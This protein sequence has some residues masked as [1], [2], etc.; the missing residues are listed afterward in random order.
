L[1]T[2]YS[3]A[4]TTPFKIVYPSG[5]QKTIY[6][7]ASTNLRMVSHVP[8]LRMIASLSTQV[9]WYAAS[10]TT[11]QKVDP[12]G[13]IDTDL[14][15]HEITTEM[16]DDPDYTIKGVLLSKQRRNPTDNP[17]TVNPVISLIS[18]RLTKELGSNSTFSFYANNFLYYEPFQHNNVTTTLTQKNEGLFAFGAEL[19]FNF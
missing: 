19:T 16:L 11:N 9:I 1:P 14:S 2:A 17:T 8:S 3:V 5:I 12:I 10:Y 18:A 13:W 15:Y 4:N 6:K 7:Q